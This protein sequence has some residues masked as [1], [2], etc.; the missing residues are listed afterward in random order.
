MQVPLVHAYIHYTHTHTY[1]THTL[2]YSIKIHSHWVEN[3]AHYHKF[4]MFNEVFQ[5]L[6]NARVIPLEARSE[7]MEGG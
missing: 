5:D 6:L 2:A 3:C 1:Y 4:V 7:R